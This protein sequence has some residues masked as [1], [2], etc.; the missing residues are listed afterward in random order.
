[1]AYR[2]VI[3][4]DGRIVSAF[5]MVLMLVMMGFGTWLP[6][7]GSQADRERAQFDLD[8]HA[9]GGSVVETKNTGYECWTGRID[10]NEPSVY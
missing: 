2:G 10:L 5:F 1:M 9:R 3:D 7:L 4:N 8:C 6:F